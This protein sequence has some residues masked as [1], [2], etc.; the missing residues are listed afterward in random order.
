VAPAGARI[1]IR[2]RAALLRLAAVERLGLG[3]LQTSVET[4]RRRG[5]VGRRLLVALAAAVGLSATV[6]AARAAPAQ[7]RTVF[8]ERQ[9]ADPAQV[10]VRLIGALG[11]GT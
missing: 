10:A 3:L 9:H 5:V 6:V 1:G 11:I 2:G 7:E 8:A 4:R